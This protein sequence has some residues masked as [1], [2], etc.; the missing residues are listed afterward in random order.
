MDTLRKA[1]AGGLLITICAVGALL[2]LAWL[3]VLLAA[4]FDIGPFK[5]LTAN[6]SPEINARILRYSFYFLLL[7]SVTAGLAL[8]VDEHVLKSVPN[9]FAALIGPSNSSVITVITLARRVIVLPFVE[10]MKLF[11]LRPRN[12]HFTHEAVTNDRIKV[13][14]S[15]VLNWQPYAEDMQM[16][17][18]ANIHQDKVL[19]DIAQRY[20]TWNINLITLDE[21]QKD[22]DALALHLMQAIAYQEPPEDCGRLYGIALLDVKIISLEL[23]KE[24][25]DLALNK[26]IAE[27]RKRYGPTPAGASGG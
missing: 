8:L 9:G 3:A 18:T 21:L 20:L 16:T 17:I 24:I 22:V 15:L 26:K 1:P 25:T 13:G 19:K 23:P 10:Q 7:V 6:L 27:L 14:L 4:G 5:G 12:L 2:L 11:D